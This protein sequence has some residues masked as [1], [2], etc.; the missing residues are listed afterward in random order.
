M[1]ADG[2]P[3]EVR[4]IR[5]D[6][7]D[8][9]DQ[10]HRRQSQ[11][12]IYYRYLQYRPE[13]SARELDRLTTV[14]YVTRMAFVALQGDELV[15]VAR[16]ER[17]ASAV[18]QRYP[19]VAFFVDDQHHRRGLATLLLEYLAAAAREHGHRHFEA[20]VLPDNHG[21]LRVFRQAGFGITTRFDDG[22]IMV[23]LDITVTDTSSAAVAD[24]LATARS[25]SV[26]RLLRPASL[27]VIGP[28]GPGSEV[29][30]LVGQVVA[31]GF[32]GPVH[33]VVSGLPPEP[34][35]LAVVAVTPD[36]VETVVGEL[37]TSERAAGVLVTT[38]MT[39]AGDGDVAGQRPGGR[40]GMVGLVRSHGMR[41]IGPGARGLVNTDPEVALRVVPRPLAPGP[42]SV[43]VLSQAGPLLDTLVGRLTI[44]GVGVSSVAAVGDRL[45]VSV[46]DLL[47]Y[48]RADPTTAVI[49][50]HSPNL[51]NLRNFA[52][53]AFQTSAATPIVTLRPAD[54]ERAELLAQ[55]GVV[56]ADTGA[57]LVDLVRL[58]DAQPL[59]AGPRVA[60]VADQPSVAGLAVAASHR[61]GLEVVV[62]T[63]LGG[64]P[65]IAT[66][67]GAVVV[68]GLAPDRIEPLLVKAGVCAD[69]DALVVALSPPAGPEAK[70][71]AVAMGRVGAS[72]DKPLVA[73]GEPAASDPT[74]DGVVWFPF[75]D[76]ATRALGAVADHAQWRRS[77]SPTV[78]YEGGDDPVD[79]RSGLL[80]W[81]GSRPEA[82]ATLTTPGAAALVDLLGLPV[83]PWALAENREAAL[84][85]AASIG[86]PV[87]L[88]VGSAAG[89][90]MGEA[91]GVAIDL[92]HGSLLEAAHERMIRPA[93]RAE[94]A[95]VQ[96]MVTARGNLRL[97][98]VQDPGLGAF[99]TVGLGGSAGRGGGRPARRY[100]PLGPADLAA[101]VAA[102]P[103]IDEATTEV[104]VAMVSRLGWLAG[105]LPELHRVTLDPV[106]IAGEATTI[107][108][109]DVVVRPW[110]TDPLSEVRRL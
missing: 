79:L 69:V 99:C 4:P 47:D 53:L 28:S 107:G 50:L 104:V 16:Y 62:P 83:A 19:E 72:V 66:V 40:A 37:A 63:S 106:L 84:A 81:L 95:V 57:D 36:Q 27:A 80:D 77:S 34:V 76:E 105:V 68:D 8:Q 30:E 35:D 64:E 85:A 90:A 21:M 39:G 103:G 48:W 3:V 102:V 88:K 7:R 1:L 58:L 10:F 46:N 15:A 61:S 23:E 38:P 5:P 60:V 25:R 86:Y 92:H 73:V 18:N 55:S 70:E 6:D 31:G 9:L 41:L 2:R 91:G 93:D 17:P 43:A 13:L 24:R 97:E 101:L 52:P 29:D 67:D 108:D 20:T 54:P 87:V 98:L 94:P 82:V 75:P 14:D 71:M 45:D 56:M 26:A 74:E 51:G 59:P 32:P 109:L 42:G 65:G 11:A 44:A 12:S 78:Q 110:S 33:Q 96:Q 49:V 100:L 22:L 89:R